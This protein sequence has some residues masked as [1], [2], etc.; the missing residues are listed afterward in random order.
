MG[1]NQSTVWGKAMTQAGVRFTTF[2]EYLSHSAQMP[3][4]GRYEWVDGVL[5]ELPPESELNI[6]VA[7]NLQFLLAIARL[8]PRR[9]IKTHTC[10]VQVASPPAPGCGQPLPRSGGA[11]SRTFAAISTTADDYPGYATPPING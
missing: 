2:E 11:P 1:E 3:L 7:D 5:V 4:E 6:W 10:E 9:L 8:I